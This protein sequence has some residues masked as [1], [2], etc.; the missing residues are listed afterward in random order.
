MF[1]IQ[2]R[3]YLILEKLKIIAYRNLFKKVYV[4]ITLSS[5]LELSPSPTAHCCR[6]LI[7]FLLPH[8]KQLSNSQGEDTDIDEVQCIIANL[9]DK[10]NSPLSLSLLHRNL[11]IL[12][13]CSPPG[14]HPRVHV[15]PAPE[16]GGQ[17]AECLPHSLICHEMT[18][19]FLMSFTVI[20]YTMMRILFKSFKIAT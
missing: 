18:T 14:L 5:S 17:Q 20:F 10:V 11:K 3:I 7:S 4:S 16:V 9:I 13:L 8:L 2:F 19:H 1:F 12:T 15:L 6:R